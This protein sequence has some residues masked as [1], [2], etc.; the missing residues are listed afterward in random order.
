MANNDKNINYWVFQ[1]NP[2]YYDIINA[3]QDEAF[4]LYCLSYKPSKNFKSEIICSSIS[5]I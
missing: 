3:L 5:L 1:G 2:K 4:V